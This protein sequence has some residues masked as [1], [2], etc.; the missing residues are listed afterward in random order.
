MLSISPSGRLAPSV[1]CRLCEFGL[2]G[3]IFLSRFRSEQEEWPVSWRL[4]LRFEG[5][6][7]YR[8]LPSFEAVSA[9]FLDSDDCTK[10]RRI[11]MDWKRERR[12]NLPGRPL[13]LH[14]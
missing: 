6:P 11:T 4:H 2:V 8:F 9:G 14:F 3:P 13:H 12:G 7:L 10:G 5:T 1:A